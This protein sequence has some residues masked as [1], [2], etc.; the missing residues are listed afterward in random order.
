MLWSGGPLQAVSRAEVVDHTPRWPFE[1]PDDTPA[2]W[3]VSNY[4][5]IHLPLFIEWFAPVLTGRHIPN[6][7]ILNWLS[8]GFVR[9]WDTAY[10]LT[11]HHISN[12]NT[13]RK[14]HILC[15]L[16]QAWSTTRTYSLMLLDL[17]FI[18]CVHWGAIFLKGYS[19][20]CRIK[21]AIVPCLYKTT[22]AH[23]SQRESWGIHVCSV[24]RAVSCFNFCLGL[25]G[26]ESWLRAL[27]VHLAIC[28]LAKWPK[29]LFSAY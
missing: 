5:T 4:A 10:H 2:R 11:K 20:I 7:M 1:E 23:S 17:T 26:Q 21:T 9:L 6:K 15:W 19:I 16:W 24:V 25:D 8:A 14:P 3:C 12:N 28:S 18:W 13:Q 22:C 27:R 29:S